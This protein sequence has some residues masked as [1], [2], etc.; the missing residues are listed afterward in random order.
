MC[1]GVENIKGKYYKESFKTTWMKPILVQQESQ[2]LNKNEN[3]FLEGNLSYTIK[4]MYE[5]LRRYLKILDIHHPCT[6]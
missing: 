1:V 2:R 5:C 3:I 6:I 4:T